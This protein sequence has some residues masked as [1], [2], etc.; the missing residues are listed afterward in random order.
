MPFR[1]WHQGCQLEG[2]QADGPAQ[3]SMASFGVAGRLHGFTY[4]FSVPI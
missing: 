2:V 3:P 1:V 4:W